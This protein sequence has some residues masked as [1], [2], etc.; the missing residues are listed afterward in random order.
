MTNK[1]KHQALIDGYS[2]EPTHIEQL[3]IEAAKDRISELEREQWFGD[4]E[5]RNRYR[6][7]FLIKSKRVAIE[8][9]GRGTHF[10]EEQREN[11]AKRQR[12]L[13]RSGYRVIRFTG[14][15]IV[16]DVNQCIKEV[17]DFLESLDI[18][19]PINRKVIYVDQLF[20]DRQTDRYMK[21]YKDTYPTRNFVRPS[22]QQVLNHVLDWLHVTSDFDIFIFKTS[23]QK[24]DLS[25]LHNT[26]QRYEKGLIK[27]RV[28][29]SEF[30]ALEILDHLEYH[31]IYYDKFILVADDS[32]YIPFLKIVN[33]SNNKL[34]RLVRHGNDETSM[35]GEGME[36]L[37]W[38]D[39]CYIVGGDVG[40]SLHEL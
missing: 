12:Y 17:I 22:T 2:V 30:I 23:N 39:I 27:Y 5:K 9:D 31:S 3:F 16:R 24:S 33:V 35:I 15:E 10:T 37:M 32:I 36:K 1:G 38:Q 4:N 6:V 19:Y 21:F 25:S 8:L 13:E 14:R 7:D 40:L 26:V 28:Y 18:Q 29:N 11:D 20:L 34:V